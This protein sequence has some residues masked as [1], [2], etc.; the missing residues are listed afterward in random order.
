[1]ARKIIQSEKA[2][3]YKLEVLCTKTIDLLDDYEIGEFLR[4]VLF[5]SLVANL[6]RFVE[7]TD[8]VPTCASVSGTVKGKI[9]KFMNEMCE[10]DRYGENKP[11]PGQCDDD[12]FVVL[13]V[14][15]RVF[16]VHISS[17]CK[18]ENNNS[19]TIN[20]VSEVIEA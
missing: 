8:C 9:S 14:G 11:V 20:A 7:K 3:G 19:I 12:P 15:S 1:M 13:K 5:S 2:D 16:H 18:V 10:P 17:S 6:Y 4:P